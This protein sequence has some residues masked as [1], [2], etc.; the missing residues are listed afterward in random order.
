MLLPSSIPSAICTQTAAAFDV[1]AGA[2]AFQDGALGMCAAFEY[3][4]LS[5]THGR[6]D[7]FLITGAEDLCRVQLDAMRALDLNRPILDGAAAI[8][9]ARAPQ[10]PFDWQLKICQHLATPQSA[11][12]PPAWRGLEPYF[13]AITHPAT[14]LTSLLIPL[15]LSQLLGGR[16]ARVLLSCAMPGRG[17]YVLGFERDCGVHE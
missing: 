9:L 3:A 4:H 6:A 2:L 7:Y 8:G 13:L 12:A 15:L 14:V 10:S 5:L 11:S 16:R 1:H 17:S